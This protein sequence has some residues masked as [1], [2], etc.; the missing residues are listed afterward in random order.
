[1]TCVTS[2]AFRL[3]CFAAILA[4]VVACEFTP[5]ENQRGVVNAP[6]AETSSV[7]MTD[8][9]PSE[10]KLPP[11]EVGPTLSPSIGATPDTTITRS[12]DSRIFV[13]SGQ[14]VR[15]TVASRSTEFSS[16]GELVVNFVDADVREVA[17]TV[18]GD[19]LGHNYLIDSKVQ[20][21][22]TL[23]SSRPLA[24]ELLMTALQAA[25]RI[26]GAALV[27]A[28]DLYKIVPLAEVVAHSR[29]IVTAVGDIPPRPGHGV[30]IVPLQFIA[31]SEMQKILEP[32]VPSGTILSADDMRSFL[33]LAAQQ[34]DAQ[35]IL[36]TIEIFDVDMLAGMSFGY[37]PVKYTDAKLMADELRAVLTDDTDSPIGKLLRF[38]PIDRLNTVLV[39]SPQP[40]YLEYAREWIRRLD[41]AGDDGTRRLFV[42]Y[43][44]NVDATELA[45]VL[46]EAFGGKR[47]D[48]R[49]DALAPDLEPV[50][51]RTADPE[52]AEPPAVNETVAARRRAPR[53]AGNRVAAEGLSA[54]A[55]G[56]VRIIPDE[57][58]NALLILATRSDY[59]IVAQALER[60][61]LIPLQVLIEATIAEVLLNDELK[62]GVE[63][64]FSSGDS[65]VTFSA[66]KD[67]AVGALFPGFSYFLDSSDVKVAI[68]AL[69]GIT[70]V[71]VIS[72]PQLMVLDNRTARLQ[73]G[74]QVP[75]A[76]QS[77]V[78][79]LDPA[80]P[81]VNS[82]QYF[83]TG[84]IL[85]VTPR[86]N[87]GGLVVMEIE[88]EVSDAV[89]TESS[90]ID[91]PTIQQRTI[92]STVA[93]QSGETVVLGGMIRER[94]TF[95]K[96]GIPI[97]SDI[98]Y[99]GPLFGVNDNKADRTEL[100]VMIT[101]RVVRNQYEARSVTDEL[102]KRM[103]AVVTLDPMIR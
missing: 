19:L 99:I 50:E 37:F 21:T 41:Q 70:D 68:N 82:I 97:L 14:F 15:P 39:I 6:A 23:Q 65:S 60:L 58:N 66:L 1:M 10:P 79:V 54:P 20:G 34:Q 73:V 57:G 16:E 71:K 48:T 17:R 32:M 52:D 72:S 64:F 47:E 95:A 44:E 36:E 13:G 8:P 49:G 93:V 4:Q 80:S 90:T 83:D 53:D 43:V 94:R 3:L 31:A 46:N 26:N 100:L 27:E 96:S 29:A 103:H 22:V 12:D 67:G 55:S 61:D 81:I 28:G 92:N 2:T 89:V 87:P 25:L 62:Y 77:A 98:P 9:R 69:S 59:R 56:S 86:V 40:R 63:W 91:S 24:R 85:S 33:I 74:D 45:E 38:V 88:Q 51:L 5:F 7:T 35:S 42:Y 18:L 11:A 30:Y 75:I 102:R 78:G 101:P 76:S 84:V